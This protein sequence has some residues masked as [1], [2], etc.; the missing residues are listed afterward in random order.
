METN[1]TF[2]LLSSLSPL[3]Y[4]QLVL[5]AVGPGG[6]MRNNDNIAFTTLPEGQERERERN[7]YKVFIYYILLYRRVHLYLHIA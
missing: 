6:V 2:L 7:L 3:T 5:E 1:S 4:Y